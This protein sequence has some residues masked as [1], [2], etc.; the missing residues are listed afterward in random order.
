M[1]QQMGGSAINY[2]LDASAPMGAK[3]SIADTAKV[4]SRFVDVIMARVNTRSDINE[5]AEEASV[6]VINALDDFAHPC[7]VSNGAVG[8]SEF[9]QRRWLLIFKQS[10]RKKVILTQPCPQ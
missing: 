10:S 8:S 9:Q 7:Q 6:P 3:E 4:L 5:L 1:I 2:P